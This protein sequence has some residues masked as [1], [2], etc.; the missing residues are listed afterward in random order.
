MISTEHLGAYLEAMG[1]RDVEGT[2]AHMADD[3]VIRSPIVPTPFQG[4]EQVTRVLV[5][6]LHSDYDSLRGWLGTVSS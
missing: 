3:V 5:V 6:P 2:K 1:R 4:R